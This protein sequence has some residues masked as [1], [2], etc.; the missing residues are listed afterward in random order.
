MVEK[1][2]ILKK[3]LIIN[4]VFIIFI[5]IIFFVFYLN[6]N[7]QKEDGKSYEKLFDLSEIQEVYFSR[8][9]FEMLAKKTN[10][11][12]AINTPVS[13]R[14]SLDILEKINYLN[15]FNSFEI[16]NIN[17]NSIFANAK[18][19]FILKIDDLVFEFGILNSVVNKQYLLFDGQVYLVPTF[20]SN[21]FSDDIFTYIEKTIIPSKLEIKTIEF[22]NWT[23]HENSL[24]NKLD[25][26]KKY[27]L[28]SDWK[29]LWTSTL[30][31]E[32][33]VDKIKF[34]SF[35]TFLDFKDNKYKLFFK[36][37]KNS[38]M[39]RFQD[40]NYIYKLSKESTLRLIEPWIFL[41]ARA[42]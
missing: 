35:I 17:K 20:F 3:K 16:V 40:E 19:S 28:P 5:S 36:E 1:K 9:S 10:N 32:I 14:M 37:T 30:S 38:F 12:W 31:S 23:Y 34:E 8:D 18:A 7:S 41:N 6:K 27:T 21:N 29:K 42:S 33:S 25:S 26:S 15:D 11:S 4:L 13:A 2:K 24:Y 22:P 39:F